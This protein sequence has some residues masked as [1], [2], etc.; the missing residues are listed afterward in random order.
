MIP[1]C[2]QSFS[3]DTMKKHTNLIVNKKVRILWT[4]TMDRYGLGGDI[5]ITSQS[6]L[7]ILDET[8]L[9]K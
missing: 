5:G 3:A 6:F 7:L 2:K 1:P 8:P 9:K 4:A